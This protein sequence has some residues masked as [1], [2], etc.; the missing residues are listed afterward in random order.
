MYQRVKS[1]KQ[2]NRNYAKKAVMSKDGEKLQERKQ[3]AE[4]WKEYMNDLYAGPL[5]TDVGI[6]K[7]GGM[8]NN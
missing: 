2:Q 1:M 3:I 7:L 4:R 5:V 8:Y 6:T